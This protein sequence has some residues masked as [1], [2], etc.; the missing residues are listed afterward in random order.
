M[1]L[2]IQCQIKNNNASNNNYK[3]Y[4]LKGVLVLKQKISKDSM[5]CL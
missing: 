1:P 3:S 4:G 5:K 2:S